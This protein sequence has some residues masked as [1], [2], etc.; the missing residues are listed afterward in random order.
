M[1]WNAL[2]VLYMHADNGMLTDEASCGLWA[3]YKTL[4]DSSEN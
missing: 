1:K 3:C 4:Q 2:Q